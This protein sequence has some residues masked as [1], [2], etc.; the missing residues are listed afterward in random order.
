MIAPSFSGH[1]LSATLFGGTRVIGG[2]TLTA[3]AFTGRATVLEGKGYFEGGA[4]GGNVLST[5]TSTGAIAAKASLRVRL[6]GSPVS[7]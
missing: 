4:A 5:G 2:Q 6:L 3:V 1:E 7:A